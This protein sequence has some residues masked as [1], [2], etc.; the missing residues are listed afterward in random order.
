MDQS[1]PNRIAQL[2]T[3]VH[4]VPKGRA[5]SYGHIGKLLPNPVSG[6]LVG[7]WMAQATSG[8]EPDSCPWWRVCARDGT[9]VIGRRDPAL[10]IEQRRRLEAEGVPFVED[11]VDMSQVYWDEFPD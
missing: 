8:S 7:R 10:A 11:R 1:S 2:W 5:T 9:L 3:A 6:L 4:K